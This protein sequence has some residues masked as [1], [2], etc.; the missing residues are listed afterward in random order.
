MKKLF[1]T[2]AVL[3]VSGTMAF[4]N[5]PVPQTFKVGMYNVQNSHTLKVFI[6]KESA[7]PLLLEIKDANGRTIQHDYFGKNKSKSGVSLN[8]ENLESG[9]YTLEISDKTNTFKKE[10]ELTKEQKEELKIVI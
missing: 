6:E 7:E 5:G 9:N 8:M 2:L 4:A 10:I 3:A 1:K